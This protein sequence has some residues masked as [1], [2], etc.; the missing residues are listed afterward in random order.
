MIHVPSNLAIHR[1][2]HCEVKIVQH[3]RNWLTQQD[4]ERINGIHASDLLDP[5]LAYWRKL[6]PKIL[7]ERQV[8]LFTIGKVL[9]SLI[10]A[11]ET[12]EV[13]ISI[14]DSGTQEALGILFS[15]DMIVDQHPVELKTNRSLYAPEQ[16]KLI[17][18]FHMYLEQ[19]IIYCV[20]SQCLIGEL[21][22]L[23]ISLKDGSGR[24][25][26][27]LR[28]YK[29]EI[30]EEQFDDM[31]QQIISTRTALEEAITHQDHTRLELCR[32]WLCGES[33][34]VWHD[35]QPQGRFPIRNRKQWIT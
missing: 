8:F 34:A 16:E 32:T 28:C 29:V 11:T 9:H 3:L 23:Y 10:L 18:D 5:R 1:D 30:T 22:V 13:D 27:G 4:S 33:C 19:L 12:H 35:C 7:T 25:F 31:E 21:W 26:P 15:P 24:T 17:E 20:L 14:S 2:E 6:K